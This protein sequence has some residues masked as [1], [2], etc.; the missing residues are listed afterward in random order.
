MLAVVQE[1]AAQDTLLNGPDLS[2]RTVASAVPERRARLEAMR[3]EDVEGEVDHQPGAVQ[4]DAGPPEFF[5]DREPPLGRPER[6]LDRARL[7]NTD[8]RVRAAR[9]HR[10]TDILARGALTVRPRNEAFE[11]VDAA[12][13]RGD[14]AGD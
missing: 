8:R 11:A 7:E 6:R 10:E 3:P 14:E 12:G 13:R 4:E 1:R 9:H 2:E 5:R